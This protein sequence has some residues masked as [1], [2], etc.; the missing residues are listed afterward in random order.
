MTTKYP[1]EL[2][3]FTNP[4]PSDMLGTTSV[5]HTTQHANANDAI[6]AIETELGVNPRGASATVKARLDALAT[7]TSTNTSGLATHASSSSAHPASNITVADAGNNWA[8]T[9]VEAALT[10]IPSLY[11]LTPDF[12]NIKVMT[13]AAYNSLTPKLST[14]LY[15]IVG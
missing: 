8:A 9:N 10:E 6:K 3:T 12:R 13:A 11:A 7:S 5:L 14:T 1:A 15:L 4:T 2:D